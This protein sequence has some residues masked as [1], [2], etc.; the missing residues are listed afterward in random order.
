M[1]DEQAR[2]AKV[3]AAADP[4][5]GFYDLGMFNDAWLALDVLAPEDKAHPLIIALRLDILLALERWGDVV[6]LAPDTL[7]S[8]RCHL[9]GESRTGR[10]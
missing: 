4:A 9:R 7:I 2:D 5:Q 10:P 1:A 6:A 3:R 8:L